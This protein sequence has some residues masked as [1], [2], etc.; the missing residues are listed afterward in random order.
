MSAKEDN[1][2]YYYGYEAEQ[3]SYYR[4]PKLLMTDERFQDLSV[5]SKLLYGMMLDRMSLSVKNEWMDDDGK[6]YIYFPVEEV[7]EKLHCRTEKATHLFAELDGK[8]GIGLI[9]RI[10]QGQGKPSR[11]YVKNFSSSGYLTKKTKSI[12]NRKKKA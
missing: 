9:D 3:Y 4:I 11:I 6:V 5:E 1:F 8:K 2:S 12:G 10:R 7:M